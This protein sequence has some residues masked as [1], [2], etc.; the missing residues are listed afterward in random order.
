M[1]WLTLY[2]TDGS[3]ASRLFNIFRTS[4]LMVLLHQILGQEAKKTNKI[5]DFQGSNKCRPCGWNIRP[6]KATFKHTV[7]TNLQGKGF[8][9]RHHLIGLCIKKI[10][11]IYYNF[12]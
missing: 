7:G 4:D 12:R 3:R 2:R 10:R 8:L 5:C 1:K 6:G 9:S 11:I